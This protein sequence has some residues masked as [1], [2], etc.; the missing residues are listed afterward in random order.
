MNIFNRALFIVI[1]LAVLA[2]GAL[3]VA[4][5]VGLL[6]GGLV[7]DVRDEIFGIDWSDRTVRWIALGAGVVLALVSLTVVIREVL[8]PRRVD[9][10][11]ELE[12]SER[13]RTRVSTTA[14]RRTY[15]RAAKGVEG[16]DRARVGAVRVSD[17]KV[18]VDI[19]AR[20][21]G[22]YSVAEVGSELLARSAH[23]I[24]RTLPNREGHV[25]A[26][27]EVAHGRRARKNTRRAQ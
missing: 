27:M 18:D 15:E 2:G 24:E 21:R 16:V 25:N 19:T 8:P 26:V 4:S 14:L 12:S 23:A 1:G 9:S 22:G 17:G 7:D 20:V 5:R 11:V 13:G 6:D 10:M 3:A